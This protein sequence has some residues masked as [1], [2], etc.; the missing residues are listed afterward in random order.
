MAKYNKHYDETLPF[1]TTF[2]S[3]KKGSNRLGQLGLCGGPV[4]AT[5]GVSRMDF[6]DEMA[7]FVMHT[8]PWTTGII[9]F[10][11]GATEFLLPDASPEVDEE[12]G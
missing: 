11:G 8:Y 7:C 4:Q 10:R 2:T 3:G 12:A 6:I 9:G 5:V 1:L